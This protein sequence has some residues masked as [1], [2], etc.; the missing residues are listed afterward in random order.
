MTGRYARRAI[1]GKREVFLP[2]RLLPL[3]AT[4]GGGVPLTGFG[5]LRDE[6]TPGF[7]HCDG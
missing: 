2:L 7:N 4:G 1:N 6:A 3:A 5:S